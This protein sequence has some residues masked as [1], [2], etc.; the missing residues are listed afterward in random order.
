MELIL[1]IDVFQRKTSYVN[2]RYIGRYFFNTANDIVTQFMKC[3]HINLLV[4]FF[5]QTV[6]HFHRSSVRKRQN[7]QFLRC[8]CICCKQILHLPE[9]RCRLTGSGSSYH[10]MASRFLHYAGHLLYIQRSSFDVTY[11]PICLIDLTFQH[12]VVM[13]L[14]ASQKK[15][16]SI[17]EG[18]ITII[19]GTIIRPFYKPKS[20]KFFFS[21]S[22][23]L[24]ALFIQ[25]L[26]LDRMIDTRRIFADQVHYSY[27]CSSVRSFKVTTI[28]LSTFAGSMSL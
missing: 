8:N 17:L 18:S 2:L 15:S 6:F 7:H 24:T 27:F 11:Q 20:T 16:L 22:L 19:E 4:S 10:Q 28:L 12:R 3:C 25:L 26:A 23:Q 13:S 21:P 14:N 1:S 5:H 9:Y